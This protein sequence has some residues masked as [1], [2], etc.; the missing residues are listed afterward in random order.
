MDDFSRM[1]NHHYRDVVEVLRNTKGLISIQTKYS[2][3][4]IFF[5]RGEYQLY[6][7]LG[8]LEDLVFTGDSIIK[9]AHSDTIIFYPAK[10]RRALFDRLILVNDFE[11]M[12]RRWVE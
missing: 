2:G 5:H 4:R 7:A 11:K 6:P 3:H 1:Q 12:K 9:N 8:Q 10:S